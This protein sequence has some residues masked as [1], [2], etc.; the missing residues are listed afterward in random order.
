MPLY[1]VSTV[2]E[3]ETLHNS[4]G[5]FPYRFVVDAEASRDDGGEVEC[6]V[7][8]ACAEEAIVAVKF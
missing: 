4:N 6:T 5:V 3:S 8:S 1:P 7:M 2:H